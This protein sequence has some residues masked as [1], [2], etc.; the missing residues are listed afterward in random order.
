MLLGA[1]CHGAQADRRV[2]IQDN[3]RY[4]DGHRLKGGLGCT[5]MAGAAGWRARGAGGARAWQR[6]QAEHRS[7]VS[8]M[9]VPVRTTRPAAVS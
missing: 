5:G 9:P 2:R 3:G 7:T 4:N 6:V 8:W 1:A